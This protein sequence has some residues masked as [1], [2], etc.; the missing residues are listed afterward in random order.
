MHGG[1]GLHMHRGC[2]H[3]CCVNAH[4][5]IHSVLDAPRRWWPCRM[6]AGYHQSDRDVESGRSELS[7]GGEALPPAALGLALGGR[8]GLAGWLG[9]A[10]AKSLFDN[11]TC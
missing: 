6:G 11:W 2:R 9:P 3:I 7:T 4:E 1:A 10:L 5:G 8:W